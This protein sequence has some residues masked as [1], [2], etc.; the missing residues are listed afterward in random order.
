M[1][2]EIK[3]TYPSLHVT[4]IHS[5]AKLLSSEPL[6]EQFKDQVLSAVQDSGVNVILQ[7]RVVDIQDTPNSQQLVLLSNGVRLSAGYVL[8]AVSKPVPSTSFLP[9]GVLDPNG[10]VFVTKR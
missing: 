4:L 1:A 6:P 8:K 3:H 7:T 5:R 9:R 2:T 10:Y